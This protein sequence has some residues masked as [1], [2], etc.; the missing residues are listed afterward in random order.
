M[1]AKRTDSRLQARRASSQRS[2][3]RRAMLMAVVALAVS[4]LGSYYLYMPQ[5]VKAV[6][7][8]ILISEVEADPPGGASAQEWIEIVNVSSA[9]I[10]LTGW[11]VNDNNSS[12]ALPTFTINPGQHVVL[13]AESAT[14]LTDHPGFTGTVI[15]IASATIGNGLAANDRVELRDNTATIIDAMSYGTDTTHFTLT[16]ATTG[17]TT[18]DYQRNSTVDTD[19]RNDWVI[20]PESPGTALYVTY[21]IASNNALFINDVPTTVTWTHT[22]GSSGPNRALIVGV[23]TYADTPLPSNRVT[24]VR[25]NGVA[26]TPLGS[27]RDGGNNSGIEM[28]LLVNPPTGANTVEVDVIALV[29]Y[30]VGG[31]ATFYGVNQ[32]TPTGT[33]ASQSGTGTNPTVNVTTVRGDMVID[34]VGTI[35]NGSLT[36]DTGQTLRWEGSPV[37]GAFDVGAG[38]TK[39]GAQG[40]TTMSWTLSASQN[41]AIGAVPVKAAFG[42]TLVRLTDFSATQTASGVAL[43]WETGYEVD[44]LGFNL[45]RESDG[46]RTRVNPSLVGGS[47]L[48]AG[49]GTALTAGRTYAWLDSKG[50]ADAQYYLEDIDLNGKRTLHGPVSP[51]GGSAGKASTKRRAELLSRL[52]QSTDQTHLRAFEGQLQERLTICDSCDGVKAKNLSGPDVQRT[53]ARGAAAK[54]SVSH[55]GFYRVGWQELTA[56]GVNPST[57]A[58]YLQLYSNGTEIPLRVSRER[59]LMRSNDYVEFYGTGVENANTDT[60]IYWLVAGTSAGRRMVVRRLPNTVTPVSKDKAPTGEDTPRQPDTTPNGTA[61]PQNREAAPHDRWN[62]AGL[63]FYIIVPREESKE[64]KPLPSSPETKTAPTETTTTAPTATQETSTPTTTEQS[65]DK[66]RDNKRRARRTSRRNAKPLRA[67]AARKALAAGQSFAYTLERRER[68]IYF[69]GLPNGEASNFFGQVITTDAVTQ[70]LGVHH[71][72]AAGTDATLEVALQGVSGDAHQVK[73]LF[74]NVAIGSIS[75]DGRE[76]QTATFTLPNTSLHDGAN[77]LK[78]TSANGETDVSLLDYV[79]LTYSH[80]YHA[81]SDSLRFQMASRDKQTRIE[82]FTNSNIRVIDITDRDAPEELQPE[83]K[84]QGDTYSASITLPRSVAAK[85]ARTLLAFADKGV[86]RPD[87][88]RGNQPSSLSDDSQSADFVIITHADFRN[89]V[90]PLAELRRNQGLTVAVVDVEDV[91]DEFSY[92][93]H[94][95]QAVHDF[96]AWTTTHWKKAPRY[97]LLVG[98]ASFDPNNYL[99]RGDVDYVPTYLTD[100][101]YMETASDDWFADFNGDGVPEM[102]VGR[103]PANTAEQATLLINKIVNYVASN[104]SQTALMVSDRTGSDGYNFEAANQQVRSLLPSNI[105]VETINRGDQPADSVRSQIVDGVNQGPM[106][107]NYMGHG[108]VEVWT[109]IAMFRSSDASSLTNG[110]QLPLFVMMTCLN[111]FYQDPSQDSLAEALLNASD[112]GAIAVWASSG[113]TEPT[114]QVL[115]NKRLVNQLFIGESKRIGDAIRE[116]KAATVDSDVRNTWIFFGDPTMIL[117]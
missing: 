110:N 71:L 85:G 99:G 47:A 74:N 66:P 45:Y 89:A 77:T 7:T 82:G 55:E 81:D 20:A 44:N 92:G 49:Q 18:L 50:S 29:D 112:G 78:L 83:V 3:R 95:P 72:D 17:T 98:D 93:A 69:A 104:A 117:R 65:T 51:T 35:A 6:S 68:V 36:P 90:T 38:S 105:G 87:E 4:A 32:T 22:T 24:A 97:V 15:D 21:D 10:T 57:D 14:F 59:G 86:E 11:T 39:P 46:K 16:P 101:A 26:L 30:V 40:T 41:W 91:Y 94:S 5:T 61:P 76:H 116:A 58:S 25:Y 106:L 31:S 115:M 75:F 48:L 107:V 52:G 111:G 9:A 8:T 113:L 42:P 13:A 1:R 54:I 102:G 43:E 84:A 114:G 27:Q 64:A 23:T 70:S 37:F 28:F 63:P 56:A 19:T 73:L 109:G 67:H 2:W 96:L 62:P 80:L 33:F 103:L 100:T 79:R 34:T 88:V 53:L 12:D 108:S 60:R